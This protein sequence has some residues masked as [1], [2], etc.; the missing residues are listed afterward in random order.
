M[1]DSPPIGD[2]T[3]TRKLAAIILLAGLLVAL[4][5]LHVQRVKGPWYGMLNW[6]RYPLPSAYGL[7][8]VS[9][10]PT[11][12]AAALYVKL[13]RGHE[14]LLLLPMLGVFS[15]KLIFA[16]IHSSAPMRLDFI[17]DAVQHPMATSYY[18]DA[19]ALSNFKGWLAEF[20]SIMPMLNLHSQT[21]PPGMILYY[22]AFIRIIGHSP[23]TALLAGLCLGLISL[24]A[25][26]ACYWFL[27]TLLEDRDS[28]FLGTCFFSLCPSY[29]LFFPVSDPTFTIL[30]CLLAVCWINSL[31]YRSLA[32]SMATG[33]VAAAILVV[34][35]NILVIGIFL[36][37]YALIA[38]ERSPQTIGK[39]ATISL[40]SCI[41]IVALFWLITGYNPIA[42]FISAWADQHKLLAQYKDQRPYPDTVWNDLFTFALG[43]GWISYLLAAYC[44][45]GCIRNGWNSRQTRIVMLVIAQLVFLAGSA[46]LA[47]ETERVWNFLLPLLMVPIA[48]EL[49]SWR[50]PARL[51]ALCCAAVVLAA[52]CRNLSIFM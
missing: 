29:V 36:F 16:A 28:A 2:Q 15:A 9:T 1:N 40:T 35:F 10:L 42:T 12:L 45:V 7:I 14:L 27:L 34:S 37:G 11:L 46:L 8:L 5:E 22:M 17:S 24:F 43:S 13:K 21:K 48:I 39:C 31:K 49:T 52:E 20:P 38:S 19:A 4:L 23:H 26:P 51:A 25:I 18:I 3:N 44:I 41:C 50:S 47:S 33:F 32:W 30:S 6:R